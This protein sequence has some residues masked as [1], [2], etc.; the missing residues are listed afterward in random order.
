VTRRRSAQHGFNMIE[1][2]LTIAILGIL[3][4]VAVPNFATWINNTKIRT[5]AESIS[6]GL[7]LARSE[8]VRRNSN[9]AFTMTGQTGWQVGMVTTVETIQTRSANEGSSG[10]QVAVTPS[11]ATIV[12]FN[13]LGRVVTNA[14]ASASIAQVAVDNAAGN[15]RTLRILVGSGGNVRMCDPSIPAPDPR[16]C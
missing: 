15:G 3:L 13:G 8:A 2:M 11:G 1:V 4:G 12:T 9:V 10:A 16:A 7:Q 5:A 14:D 6:S